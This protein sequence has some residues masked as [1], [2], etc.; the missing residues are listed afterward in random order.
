MTESMKNFLAKIS[1]DKALAEKACKLEKDELIALAKELGVEL[2]EADFVQPEG[3]IAE[4]ELKTI[5]GG[6]E[7]QCYLGGGGT[8]ATYGQYPACGCV[9]AGVGRDWNGD[10]FRCVCALGGYGKG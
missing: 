1:G 10:Y 3:E 9:L 5:S 7:C 4:N 8:K 6:D 2:T